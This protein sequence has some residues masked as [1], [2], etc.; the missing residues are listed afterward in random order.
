MGSSLRFARD[1]PFRRY[2]VQPF[3]FVFTGPGRS[4]PH[5]RDDISPA[6][7]FPSKRRARRRA[8]RRLRSYI[9]SRS[10]RSGMPRAAAARCNACITAEAAITN[11]CTVERDVQFPAPVPGTGASIALRRGLKTIDHSGL[12][13]S[14]CRRTASR[15]R[16]LIRLRTTALPSARGVVKPILGPPA[17]G[18]RT[19]NAAKK[20][21]EKREPLS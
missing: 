13:C 4:R 12:N 1:R 17:C 7:W 18:S 20:G 16:R 3:C 9:P 6:A 19:Q 21:L 11:H 2:S 15:T 10:D 5:E 14:R 8:S